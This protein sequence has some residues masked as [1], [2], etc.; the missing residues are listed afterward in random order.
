MMYNLNVLQVKSPEFS[1]SL[2]SLN[3]Q[4]ENV[5]NSI[6]YFVTQMDYPGVTSYCFTTV[7]V[8][9][10]NVHCPVSTPLL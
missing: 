1:L 7:P 4:R 10:K 8:E 2:F 9:S 6:K 5:E 3:T